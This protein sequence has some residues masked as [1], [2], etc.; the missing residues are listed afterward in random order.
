MNLKHPTIPVLAV[1][2]IAAVAI[3]IASTLLE[4]DA[5]QTATY[6]IIAIWWIP[7]S[8]LAARNATKAKG[9]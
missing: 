6:L 4:G 1:S 2:L 8:V 7:F 9:E 5:A 3:L